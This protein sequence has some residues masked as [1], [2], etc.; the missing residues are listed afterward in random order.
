MTLYWLLASAWCCTIVQAKPDPNKCVFTLTYDPSRTGK[1]AVS[2]SNSLHV[3]ETKLHDVSTSFQGLEGK[4]FNVSNSIHSMEKEIQ[5]VSKL[6]QAM[7]ERM[8][9][10]DSFTRTN[11]L[12]VR[13]DGFITIEG[14]WHVKAFFISKSYHDSLS[15][16]KYREADLLVIDSKQKHDAVK[17]YAKVNLE[18]YWRDD[19]PFW[20]N[21][22]GNE[23]KYITSNGTQVEYF[24]WYIQDG[25]W[26]GCL[27]ISPS[28]D[29][30]YLQN[31]CTNKCHFF[32]EKQ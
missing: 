13:D 14:G 28:L 5:S 6:Q 22:K 15:F 3:L 10:L 23:T 30:K 18:S 9:K 16:C 25:I 4:L 29:Y 8:S 7:E 11:S 24:D 20:I 17:R 31:L 26:N 27:I 32:C 21:G 12:H 2:V 1:S 19:L